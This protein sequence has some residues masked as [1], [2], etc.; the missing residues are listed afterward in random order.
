MLAA[1]QVEF[2]QRSATPARVERHLHPRN[3]QIL[4]HEPSAIVCSAHYLAALEVLHEGSL[5][6]DAEPFDP[7]AGQHEQHESRTGRYVPHPPVG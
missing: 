7:S 4:S 3:V 2:G 5:Q 1:S 6:L